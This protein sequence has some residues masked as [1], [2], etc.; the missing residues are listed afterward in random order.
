MTLTTEPEALADAVIARVNRSSGLWQQFGFL[1][2]VVTVNDDE[3]RYHDEVPVTYFAETGLMSEHHTYDHA[4][5]VTLEYGP[6]HDKIDPFDVTV[7]RTAQDDASRAHDAAYLHPV[8]RYHR[9]GSPVATH[10]LAENL[11]NR[12]DRPEVHV[13]P[14]TEFVRRCL[15]G[16][17]G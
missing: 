14:L 8:V 7:N 1:G 17:E 16:A 13:K 3:A 6:D 10:H 2:D 12:W 4:F 5:V 9:E 11:E 15:S